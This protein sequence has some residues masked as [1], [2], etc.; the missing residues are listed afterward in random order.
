MRD[1]AALLR[2]LEERRTMPFSWGSSAN[3]CASFA[4]RA[5]LAQTGI[6]PLGDLVWATEDEAD[7]LIDNL[8]GQHTAVSARL[9]EITP[10]H[11]K[12]GDVA[13]VEQGNRF[14]LMIVETATVVGPGI[15]SIVRRPRSAVRF[16]WSAD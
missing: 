5:V 10:A 11:A 12:R 7:A 1:H 13:G 15:K 4:A 16:A 2:F 3:D 14:G 9:R 8:G 6:D